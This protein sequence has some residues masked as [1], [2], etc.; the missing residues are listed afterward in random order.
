MGLL[1]CI[2]LLIVINGED[3]QS[4]RLLSSLQHKCGRTSE[5]NMSKQTAPMTPGTTPLALPAL[6]CPNKYVTV[7]QQMCW[8]IHMSDTQTKNTQERHTQDE[9]EREKT[10]APIPT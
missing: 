4:L 1:H 3:C 9:R 5:L 7:M 6:E 8:Y 10:P 2:L